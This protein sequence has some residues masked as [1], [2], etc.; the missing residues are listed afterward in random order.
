MV[1]P[2]NAARKELRWS[3]VRG[4]LG[5][6]VVGVLTLLL[7]GADLRTSTGYGS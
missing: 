1:Q 5:R 2:R 6:E 7:S 4:T 3:G